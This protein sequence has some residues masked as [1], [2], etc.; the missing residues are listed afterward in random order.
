MPRASAYASGCSFEVWGHKPK[1]RPA[2]FPIVGLGWRVTELKSRCGQFINGCRKGIGFRVRWDRWE[3]FYAN[4]PRGIT[5]VQQPLDMPSSQRPSTSLY[6]RTSPHP[7]PRRP[8]AFLKEAPLSTISKNV[9]SQISE[10][11]L[12]CNR[13]IVPYSSSFCALNLTDLTLRPQNPQ[14]S[15]AVLELCEAQGVLDR[16]QGVAF[17]CLLMLSRE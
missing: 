8:P 17:L 11:V 9:T 10:V 2:D 7:C 5:D 13:R 14:P 1:D 3:T 16:R 4:A 15:V 12:Y 6:K